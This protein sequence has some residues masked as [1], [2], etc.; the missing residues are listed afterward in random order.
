MKISATYGII[1][2]NFLYA[3]LISV[4]HHTSCREYSN[5]VTQYQFN[6][7]IARHSLASNAMPQNLLLC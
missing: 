5:S 6:K 3:A 4:T 7:T 1:R 2:H